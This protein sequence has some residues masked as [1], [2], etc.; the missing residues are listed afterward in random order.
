M[1]GVATYYVL[2]ALEVEGTRCLRSLV[3]CSLLFIGCLFDRCRDVVLNNWSRRYNHFEASPA[4]P[5]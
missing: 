3:G 4:C 1:A 5:V 2:N